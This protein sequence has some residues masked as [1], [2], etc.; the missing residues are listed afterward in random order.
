MSV[1]GLARPG[2]RRRKLHQSRPDRVEAHIIGSRSKV[3]GHDGEGVNPPG[4]AIRGSPKVHLEAIAVD[5]I[6]YDI[7]TAVAPGHECGRSH[8]GTGG[9]IVVAY[10]LQEHTRRRMARINLRLG[11]TPWKARVVEREMELPRLIAVER[12]MPCAT[13]RSSRRGTRQARLPSGNS[14]RRRSTSSGAGSSFCF[15]P[16]K[17]GIKLLLCPEKTEL[18]PIF[19]GGVRRGPRAIARDGRFSYTD[20]L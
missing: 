6:A 9:V 3:A 15:V 13:S 2:P 10:H 5:I 19:P 11:L 17:P 1:A 14:R 12:A 16:K 8:R 18:T 7:L 4:T 20:V